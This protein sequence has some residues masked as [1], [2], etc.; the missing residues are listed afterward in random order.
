MRISVETILEFLGAGNTAEDIL[1][2]YPSL[3]KE[4]VSVCFNMLQ[5]FQ[6]KNFL[7]NH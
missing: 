1:H 3:E 6:V 7:F 2:Q 5:K 4:D